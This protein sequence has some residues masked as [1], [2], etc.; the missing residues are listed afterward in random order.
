MSE[1]TSLKGKELGLWTL[2]ALSMGSI[3]PLAFAVSNGAGAVVY[4]GFAAPVVPIFAALAILLVSVPALMFSRHVSFAG[5]YYGFAEKGFGPAT[6][7]YVAL[8]NL[9][10]YILMDVVSVVAVS[11]ILS[12]A[13]SELYGY[14]LP[15]AIYILVALISTFLMFLFTVLDIKISGMSVLVIVAVQIII[16]LIF[17]LITIARTPY[18]SIQAFNIAKAPAGITGVMFASVTAGFLFFTGYGAPFYFA[19]E[20]KTSERTVWRSIILS[21][22]IL[23]VVSVIVT[24][25]E[26]AAVGLS[27][28]SSLSTDWNP[29]VVA[30]G[31]YVGSIGTLAFIIIALIGQMWAGIVGGMSGARLIYAM[32]R[33]RFLFPKSFS[34]TH[35]KYHTPVYGALFEL[36]VTALLTILS[37]IVLVRIYG[38]SQGIFYS[39]FLFGALTTFMWILQHLI[40]DASS[41]PFFRK[42]HGK[43]TARVAAYTLIPT[44]AA[45]ALFIYADITSYVGIGEPYLAGLYVIFA[46]LI[47][48]LIYII[49]MHMTH[50]LESMVSSKE[51]VI[52]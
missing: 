34:R 9:F 39:L 48:S 40:A 16:V 27:N 38:Y 35:R 30:F 15:L 3:Y 45:A 47:A 24:Y 21:I 6:G 2:V 19:E 26:V 31:E 49:Y 23:T 43:L 44:V 32:A 12:T 14:T 41:V 29:A 37:P 17:S 33:D 10:Y 51:E 46:L 36:T 11:Y 28:A 13:L 22:V 42:L 20:T 4:A 18:N 7:K 50:R 5:G 1:E 8:V 25:A 52:E